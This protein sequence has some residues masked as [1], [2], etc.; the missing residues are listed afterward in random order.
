MAYELGFAGRNLSDSITGNM[1]DATALGG[2]RYRSGNND[3]Y[4]FYQNDSRSVVQSYQ[5]STSLALTKPF[6]LQLSNISLKWTRQ[7][8]L[9]PDT[10][11]FDTVL[12]FP[13]FSIAA[14]STVLDKISLINTFIKGTNVSSAFSL[15]DGA[16]SSSDQSGGKVTDDGYD[17]S[18]LI[19][20]DG[21]LKK[22]PIT[23]KYQHTVHHE[24]TN[25]ASS[26]TNTSS[27][28]DRSGDNL[29]M[30]YE[31]PK[32]ASG[33]TAIKLFKWNLPIRGK[34]SMGLTLTRD[35]QTVVTA[36]DTTT[37]NSNLSLTPHISYIFTD[38]VTGTLEY[39]G[40]WVNT[41]G[42]E[43]TTNTVSLIADIKF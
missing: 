40:S 32:S 35:R 6:D 15:K 5:V 10:S 27:L 19:S 39:T 8:S 1:N 41:N 42:Q 38:N 43:T 29:D 18:P 21:T 7:F 36:G 3:N 25:S 14:H 34:T 2:M 30:T 31:L 16:T 24:V 37:N 28:T 33:A 20:V 17:L 26:A 11:Y 4:N 12:T 22:W 13:E 9:K 23:F